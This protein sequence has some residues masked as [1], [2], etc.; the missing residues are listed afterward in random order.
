LKRAAASHGGRSEAFVQPFYDAGQRVWAKKKKKI[1]T[2]KES[3]S[4]LL[5]GEPLFAMQSANE[6]RALIS[7]ISILAWILAQLNWEFSLR[8]KWCAHSGSGHLII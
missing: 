2:K 6:P 5:E 7:E 8:F 4:H 1:E 3:G